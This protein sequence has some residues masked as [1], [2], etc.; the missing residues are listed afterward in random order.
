MAED[1]SRDR[2]VLKR[3]YFSR[4]LRQVQLVEEHG[5]AEADEGHGD[6]GWPLGGIVVVEGQHAGLDYGIRRRSVVGRGNR[7]SAGSAPS[8]PKGTENPAACV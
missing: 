5:H 7:G 1:E 3:E 2:A 6:D 8:S 4:L